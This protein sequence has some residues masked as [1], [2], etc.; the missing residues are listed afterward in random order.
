METKNINRTGDRKREMEI[1]TELILIENQNIKIILGKVTEKNY[2]KV[3]LKLESEQKKIVNI[4]KKYQKAGLIKS[5]FRP[6]NKIMQNKLNELVKAKIKIKK[7]IN[8]INT[9]FK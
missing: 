9:I 1:L 2:L 6:K 7:S 3:K 8:K 4:L 5:I